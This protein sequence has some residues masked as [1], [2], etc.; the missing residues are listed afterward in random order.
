M[1]DTSFNKPALPAESDQTL[2]LGAEA[3]GLRQS[4]IGWI[5]TIGADI[6]GFAIACAIG[7]EPE[8][9]FV[10]GAFVGAIAGGQIGSIN[11]RLDRIVIEQA[12]VQV[13]PDQE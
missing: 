9:V 8:R 13:T 10:A 4:R 11:R 12:A 2:S 7:L 6:A 3:A 1:S 5:A